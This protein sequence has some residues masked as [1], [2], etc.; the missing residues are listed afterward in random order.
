MTP[1]I[2]SLNG[3]GQFRFMITTVEKQGLRKKLIDACIAKQ[4]FLIDDFKERI[5]A[6]TETEGLGN[7]ESFDN[8][9]VAG[10][11]AKVPEINTLNDLLTF[12]NTELELLENL[13]ITQDVDREYVS[14][15][16]IVVTNHH[17]FFVSASL[18][19]FTV[20]G[21]LYVGISTSSPIYQVMHGKRRGDAFVFNGIQYKIRDVF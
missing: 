10:N 9:D 14:P 11:S 12:A 6:L 1:V 20:R 13:R 17:T 3:K 18:E 15:G 2:T 4:Q 8:S 7:E 19:K 16:A 5:K 21:H